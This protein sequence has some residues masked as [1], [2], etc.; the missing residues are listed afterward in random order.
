[1]KSWVSV[2]S[3]I[4]FLLSMTLHG[5]HSQPDLEALR[6]EVLELHKSAIEAHLNNHVDFLVQNLSD[7]FISVSNGE[8]EYPTEEELRSEFSS[9]LD[10]TTFSEYADLR[11]PIIGFSKDGSIAW[12]I[13]QVKVAG[14]RKADDGSERDLDFTCAWITLYE[15]EDGRWM[16]LAEVSSFK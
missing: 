14:K 9:Y 16:K 8:I 3:T 15:R 7:D 1:M 5:C 11:E 13:V 10:N 12:S 2:L 6:S 4:L